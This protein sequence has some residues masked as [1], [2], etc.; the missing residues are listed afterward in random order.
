MKEVD[1]II[2]GFGIAG[3]SL[4]FQLESIGKT[5]FVID[6]AETKASIVAAGLYNPVILKRFTLAWDVE[7]QMQYAS[8]FYSDLSAFLKV[9]TTENLAV[10]RK[11]NNIEEQNN[12]FRSIDKPQLSKYLSPY[13][14]VSPSKVIEG[15]FKFGEVRH[16]GRVLVNDIFKKYKEDLLAKSNYSALEFSFDNLVIEEDF[17]KYNNVK[18][19]KIVFCEGFK[20]K[21]N[22]YFNDLPL[23]GNKGSY[24]I[25]K[26]IDLKLKVALKSYYFIIPMGNN[27]YKFGATYE[28]HFKN[29][30]HSEATREELINRLEKLTEASYE[31]ID[32][33]TGVRPTVKDRRPLLGQH[34]KHKQLYVLNGMGTR[35]VLLAP[36]ASHH[37]KEFMEA[38][39]PLPKEID[40]KRFTKTS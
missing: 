24:L 10:F 18:A 31:I 26:C 9:E 30:K 38:K 15:E 6:G 22:P 39:V 11:F 2:V 7:N 27:L 37:L 35:G 34:L 32:Q 25:I 3:M 13:L 14:Q 8:N 12:W 23:I 36:V 4:A 16:T 40:I 29:R 28:N 21:E 1:Y 17:V 19:K 33:V 20:L 5:I